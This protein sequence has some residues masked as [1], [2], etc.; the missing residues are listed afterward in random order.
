MIIQNPEYIIITLAAIALVVFFAKRLRKNSLLRF[1]TL[2]TISKIPSARPGFG[3]FAII[4]LEIAAI[5]LTGIALARPRQGTQD[6]KV[7]TEGIDIL[8]TIDVSSSMLAEDF[9]KGKKRF[10]R[11]EAVKQVVQNF[12]GK[13]K[14]DRIGAIVFGKNPYTLCPLT[15]D[16]NVLGGFVGQA[17]IG[18]VEDGTGI[19]SAIVTSLMRFKD[20]KAKSKII[21]LLTDGRN[22]SGN[23]DP[24]AAAQL[25]ADMG[26][27]IYTIGAGSKG[28][29]PYPATDMFGRKTYQWVESDLDED[30][31]RKI[32]KKTGGIYFNATNT[33][34]LNQIYETIDKLEKTKIETN[35]YVDYQER[36]RVFALAALLALFACTVLAGTKYKTLP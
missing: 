9:T 20:S 6:T 32:A 12:I 25:A 27:K 17:Q 35:V 7:N 34:K 30:T 16:Y 5:A 18:M 11:L 10:N 3:R 8:L 2:S 28:P 26:I 29:A 19:G 21:I 36:F 4:G 14:Y 23:I 22:N 33:K 24:L 1:S 31:L 13:R 15:L